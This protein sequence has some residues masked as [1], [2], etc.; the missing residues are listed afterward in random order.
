M[1][2][3]LK[4]LDNSL[5]LLAKILLYAL[6]MI[7]F[8]FVMKIENPAIAVLSRTMGITLSTYVMSG[9]LFLK[10]YGKYDIG[11]KKSKPIIYSVSLA[12]IL[13]DLVTYIQIMIMNTV[14]PNW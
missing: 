13:T 9:V 8:I 11:R 12:V 1:K 7:I 2:R 4:K 10:V 14:K 3:I 6:M 5:L